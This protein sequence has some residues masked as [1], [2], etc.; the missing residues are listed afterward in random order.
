[1]LIFHNSPVSMRFV[2]WCLILAFMVSAT[3]ISAQELRPTSPVN[4]T[5]VA[6]TLIRLR[7]TA[8]PD[9]S[10]YEVA[11]GWDSLFTLPTVQTLSATQN[12]ITI[13]RT[14][15]PYVPAELTAFWRVRVRQ[16]S[17]NVSAWSEVWRFTMPVPKTVPPIVLNIIQDKVTIIPS[18]SGV[19]E[20]RIELESPQW[21]P[22]SP[23]S[24]VFGDPNQPIFS[25]PIA[26]QKTGISY[27]AASTDSRVVQLRIRLL[28]STVINGTV[29]PRPTL[30]YALLLPPTDSCR[31]VLI[32]V[33]GT[34]LSGWSTPSSFMLLPLMPTQATG[35]WN[36]RLQTPVG[37]YLE[38]PDK[39]STTK[40]PFGQMAINQSTI[41]SVP[42]LTSSTATNG[43][44]SLSA[45]P[46]VEYSLSSTGTWQPSLR[47]DWRSGQP[48]LERLWL[49][50]TPQAIGQN[51]PV[52]RYVA[53]DS[54][55]ARNHGLLR[56][57]AIGMPPVSYAYTVTSVRKTES[58]T[59]PLLEAVYPNPTSD[60]ATF[61]LTLPTASNVKLTMYTLLGVALQ[62]VADDV[63]S[64]GRYQLVWQSGG[65]PSGVYGYRL[66][67][68]GKVQSG[69]VNVVR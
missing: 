32:T 61:T 23:P 49:R 44:L 7:W 2:S 55:D 64:A 68:G 51:F 12:T 31:A 53:N 59:Q 58:L 20:D 60:D 29:D 67:A 5:L 24:S 48:K 35:Y 15:L 3:V 8:A 16:D 22:N 21:R 11:I 18:Y 4:A 54:C 17:V 36:I 34:N 45:V 9:V 56:I 43:W 65:L 1:M 62:T 26:P 52:I 37:L 57:E 47:V 33:I 69:L 6:D 19:A 42:I 38:L 63:F 14:S 66:E 10:R 46:G 30:Y 25:T 40:F 27:K 39:R 41:A 50:Y 13:R 28:D